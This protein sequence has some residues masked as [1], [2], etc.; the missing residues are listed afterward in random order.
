MHPCHVGSA[1]RRE[2]PADFNKI[3]ISVA[4]A[5]FRWIYR[6]EPLA[7]SFPAAGIQPAALFVL[8]VAKRTIQPCMDHCSDCICILPSAHIYSHIPF[9]FN[10]QLV[11]VLDNCIF[12]IA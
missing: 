5:H 2:P 12:G 8:L 6:R 9:V 10:I 4:R 7:V 3:V 1:D 11:Q